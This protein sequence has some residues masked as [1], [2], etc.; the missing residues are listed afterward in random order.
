M[1]KCR[2]KILAGSITLAHGRIGLWSA[3][4]RAGS[5]RS[6]YVRS[7]KA[8]RPESQLFI[9]DLGDQKLRW[10]NR[11]GAWK[12]VQEIRHTGF[13]PGQYALMMSEDAAQ[14]SRNVRYER[15]AQMREETDEIEAHP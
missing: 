3:E 8:L 4:C 10:M 1:G 6:R 7:A 15:L 13:R 12:S 2:Y 11:H 14:S 5:G 9:R